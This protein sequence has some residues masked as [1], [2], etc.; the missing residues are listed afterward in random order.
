MT[1]LCEMIQTQMDRTLQALDIT[2][3]IKKTQKN[4]NTT[5]EE[6]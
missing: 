6:A 1:F 2:G 4:K 5:I 3:R